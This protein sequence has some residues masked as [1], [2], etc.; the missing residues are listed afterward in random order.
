YNILPTVTWYARDL[1]RPI[2]TEQALSIA[3]DASGRVNDLENEALAWLHAFTKN[4]GVSPSKVE[5]DNA[6]PRL[7]H[8]SFKSGKEANLFK[9]FLPPAGAL[10]PFVP[11]QL[12][13]APGQK[14]LAKDASGAYVVTVERSIG[15]HLTPEQ[16]KKL[17]HFS[18]KMTPERTV[19]PFY[20]ELVYG[21]VQQIAN[22]LFGPTLEALQVSALAKNPKDETLR[23]QAVA[24]AGEIQSVEK[25]FGKES[26]LAKRIYASFSQIDHSNKK[27]LISQFGAALKTVREELQKQLDGIVAKEKKAQDEGTLLNVSDS[28]TARLL[29]K[30][31][32]TLKNAEKI[33]AERAD[34]FASGAAPPTEAK[35]AEVWQ[36]SSK[37][38]DPNSF[39]QTLDLAGYSPYFA[40]LEV[41][42][43]DDRIN[44]KTYPDVTALRDKI[45]GTEAESFK[46]EALNRMLFNAVARASRLSDETI[47]PKGDDFLVQLNTLTGSQAV[48]ALDLGKVAALEADQVASAIQQGWNPQHPDFSA[49]SFPVRS[50]SDFLKDPTPKQKLGLVVIAPAALDKEAPQG[51]SGRSIYIVA[52]GLEPILKK[53]Q[54][55]ADSEEGKAL[56]TD[57][58]RLQT[59]LQQYGYIGYP[60]RAFNFD[61]KF[62]KDYV[63]EKR[64]Y[65]DD[66]LSAT[67]EDF[68]VK[69][70]KRFAVLELTDLEQRI[71]TQNKIDD[72]IQEDLVK[73]QE[74]YSRAQVDLNP[75]SRYTVPAPTQN[76]YLS[77]LAL[78]AKKYFRGDD[79]K[80]LKWG[81]DLSGGK[82]VRIGLRDS[83]NRPVTDPEDLTQAVNELYTR[84]NR[85]G[86]SERTIRIEGENIIL[87]FPGSQAL[88]ASELVKASAMYFHIVNE[89]FGPQNKE[90]APLVNEFLQEIWN[91]AVV[92]NRRDSDSINEIAWKHLGGD[93]ENP[94][95][96]LPKSDTAQA[97][98][99]NGLR[100]SNPYTDKRTV[101][102]D[103]KVSMI[104]KFRG[105][106]PSEWYG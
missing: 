26:P 91:E 63:F 21:R 45:L 99:D 98:F 62:Q 67:R 44:L 30:Q 80:V 20:E 58:E 23:D 25:L 92:T 22:G 82:T 68:Q 61:S 46:A 5:L 95:Q 27:E 53:S 60:A 104:A 42:W 41:D 103:D 40:A 75:A 77:N 70:D 4:L 66:L 84:I 59:L 74:E 3:E 96:V 2:D 97:L 79:R 101:A 56:F 87:D 43:T 38:I 14:E 33:V 90:L 69:G 34:L 31:V 35:L 64:D 13:L 16:T 88:S 85:M 71:L 52:R 89:K 7:I 93:P 65:Y 29:E 37:T 19:S 54:G 55:D 17:Y 39:I 86:V 47:Q 9:K 6:S 83:S 81:L 57:F 72:R 32:A 100:L 51:F 106:S 8:V 78:S 102:F 94:D 10:I 105:D 50:Y 18:K 28:Q 15:I 24:L 73:W 36:S 12:K 49:S 1:N 76:P 11:A 48:L